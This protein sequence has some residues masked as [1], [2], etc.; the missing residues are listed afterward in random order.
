[1]GTT[2]KSITVAGNLAIVGPTVGFR[3]SN[4]PDGLR[5]RRT[6]L[7]RPAVLGAFVGF[8]IHVDACE[9]AGDGIGFVLPCAHPEVRRPFL[10]PALALL[11]DGAVVSSVIDLVAAGEEEGQGEEH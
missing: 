3:L 1:M 4:R 11:A 6:E 2:E 8:E 10:G 7:E 9:D 5:L